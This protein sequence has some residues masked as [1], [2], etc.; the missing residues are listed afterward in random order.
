MLVSFLDSSS[1][2]HQVSIESLSKIKTDLIHSFFSISDPFVFKAFS[3]PF[4]KPFDLSKP[5]SS[6]A[7]AVT[8]P[9]ALVW[10]SAMDRERQ[11]LLDMGAFEEVIL[12]KGE[13]TIGLKWVISRKT[14]A[15]VL[16]QF[17]AQKNLEI[18]IHSA[19][20]LFKN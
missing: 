1:L 5:P 10:H 20:C 7:E 18:G 12:P 4:S 16:L 2:F 15:S 3:P 11:S 13:Q 9:D 17:W 14:I 8:R 6:Y 19:G